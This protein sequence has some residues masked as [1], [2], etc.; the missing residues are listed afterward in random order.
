MEFINTAPLAWI[1]MAWWE[2]RG[3]SQCSLGPPVH[4]QRRK[5]AWDRPTGTEMGGEHRPED[6]HP[7]RSCPGHHGLEGAETFLF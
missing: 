7:G 4:S 6:V 5:L 1:W 3:F 2:G